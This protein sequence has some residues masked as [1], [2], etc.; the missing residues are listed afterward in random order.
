MCA[1][2][3]DLLTVDSLAVDAEV[4]RGRQ[5]PNGYQCELC[6]RFFPS[7]YKRVRHVQMEHTLGKLQYDC[8]TCGLAFPER[9]LLRRH[10][11]R[12]TDHCG[13]DE[14]LDLA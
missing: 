1:P 12:K 3:V 13:S 10:L 9:Y 6:L 14:Y 4:R 7:R 5:G 8:L 2:C 11:L